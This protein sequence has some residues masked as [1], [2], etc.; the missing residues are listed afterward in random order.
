[1]AEILKTSYRLR[2]DTKENWEKEN[3][4]LLAGEPGVE[5]V[6]Q[7]NNNKKVSVNMKIGDGIH[8]W[9]EL[10]YIAEATISDAQMEKMVEHYLTTHDDL[11]EMLLD[12]IKYDEDTNALIFI[13]KATNEDGSQM[14]T[15]VEL[16]DMLSPYNAGEG[17][18]IKNQTISVKEVNTNLIFQD[19]NDY[20]ILG[21]KHL[22]ED[23]INI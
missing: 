19:D 8:C 13:W 11:S 7:T 22:I 14:Q 6:K 23:S 2:R 16:T 15:E 10:C 21:Y 20:L 12:D 17:I 18:N 3:P 9:N 4:V 5:L 1:M